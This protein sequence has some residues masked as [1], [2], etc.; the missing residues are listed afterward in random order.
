MPM[1]ARSTLSLAPYCFFF[2]PLGSQ[3]MSEGAAR[4]AADAS[5]V[6]LRK[7]MTNYFLVKETDLLIIQNYLTL[8][9]RKDWLLQCY[10]KDWE[11]CL[12]TLLV[13][14]GLKQIMAV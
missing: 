5:A 2:F 4:R 14:L 6:S 8:K 3:E 11:Q 9:L 1:T 10:L 7:D 12:N 13:R